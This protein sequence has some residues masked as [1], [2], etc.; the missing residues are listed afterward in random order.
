MNTIIGKITSQWKTIRK[1]FSDMNKDTN[2]GGKITPGELKFYF[3]HWG[4]KMSEEQ[5]LKIYDMFDVDKDGWISY[6][7]F[8]KSVG[9]EIHPGESLYFRQDKPFLLS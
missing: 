1:A 8:H 7:D 2:S 5:F 3:N 9:S 4:L 6:N